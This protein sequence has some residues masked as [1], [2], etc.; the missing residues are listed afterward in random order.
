MQVLD[1]F[2]ERTTFLRLRSAVEAP[3]FRWRTEHVLKPDS[4]DLQE[5]DNQQEVHGLYRRKGPAEYRSNDF[6]LVLPVLELLR[7]AEL[8]RI[9][10]NRTPR[11]ERHLEYGLHVDTTRP[12]ATTA[13]LYLNSNNGYTLFEGGERV[14]S[15]A[16]R[17][18]IFDAARRHTGA[19]CT[20]ADYRLV[21][22]V[23]VVRRPA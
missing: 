14:V 3:A 20:D 13:I 4:T 17:I 5:L 6:G 18:V 15:V 16:N 12:G 22:N 10:L 21:L 23:N 19:T 7:P 1:D 2:L 8:I 9:K 11:H